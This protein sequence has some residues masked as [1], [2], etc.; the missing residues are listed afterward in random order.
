MAQGEEHKLFWPSRP[1]FVRM[2][3]KFGA[4][5][6]PFGAVGADDLVEVSYEFQLRSQLHCSIY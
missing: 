6:I 4:K 5:I 1:E 2:A 3:A